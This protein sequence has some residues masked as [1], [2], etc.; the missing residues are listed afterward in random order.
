MNQKYFIG[1]LI[2]LLFLTSCTS[3]GTVTNASYKED[4][5]S[6]VLGPWTPFNEFN[7]ENYELF[8]QETKTTDDRAYV[9]TVKIHYTTKTLNNIRMI[10]LPS[11]SLDSY[12]T[13]NVA[14]IGYSKSFNL[15]PAKSGND[16]P[17]YK[18]QVEKEHKQ[19]SLYVSIAYDNSQDLIKIDF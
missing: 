14:T 12:S 3:T 2:P 5:S 13:T 15:V 1:A 10:I 19:E 9:Y 18:L 6:L 8:R 11:D 4:L 17:M 16:Y 7:Q